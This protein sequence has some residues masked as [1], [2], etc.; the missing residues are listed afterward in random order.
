VLKG[1][2]DQTITTTSYAVRQATEKT[3][4]LRIKSAHFNALK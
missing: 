3:A 2:F 1:N 4:F